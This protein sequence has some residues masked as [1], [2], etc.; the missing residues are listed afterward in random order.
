[1][2][3]TTIVAVAVVGSLFVPGYVALSVWN[4]NYGWS[5]KPDLQ[6]FASTMLISAVAHVPTLWLVPQ[7]LRWGRDDAFVSAGPLWALVG[8]FLTV[9]LVTPSVLG[10]LADKYMS[11][12]KTRWSIYVAR[13]FRLD[14]VSRAPTA[15]D[16][17][18]AGRKGRFV[19]AKLSDGRFVGGKFGR[20][21]GVAFWRDGH[22][23]YLE[24]EWAVDEN[25]LFTA[26]SGQV[27]ATAGVWLR[28]DEIEY[29]RLVA[30]ADEMEGSVS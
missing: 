5:P 29:V 14:R 22:D 28:G 1:V 17:V 24:E 10:V 20:K 11:T 25:G 19:V 18:W 26:A 8:W 12:P 16:M 9:G 7:L 3:P 13:M 2:I 30:T 21:S 4:R 23:L 15:W 6:L 27:P